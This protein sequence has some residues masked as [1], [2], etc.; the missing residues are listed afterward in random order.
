MPSPTSL[1]QKRILLVEDD[2]EDQ[3][4]LLEILGRGGYGVDLAQDGQEALVKARSGGH[5][6]IL[7]DAVLP[8]MDGFHVARLLKFDA[9]TKAIPILMLTG[10]DREAT[11]QR[12]KEVGVD[13]Y[14]TKP[15]AE[16]DLLQEI[17]R[18]IGQ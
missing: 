1:V 11:R 15:V 2:P 7:L 8:R 5:G 18:M 13:G 16:A 17:R 6:L 14:L 10:L 12:G 9:K 3:Q 4:M